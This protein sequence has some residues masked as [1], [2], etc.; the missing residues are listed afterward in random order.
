MIHTL[1]SRLST[2]ILG[3]VSCTIATLSLSGCLSSDGS[4]S[5]PQTSTPTMVQ[6]SE[7]G[8]TGIELNAMLAYRGIPYAAAPVDELRFA[9][10]APPPQ[11][12]EPLT[13]TENF[14]GECPQVSATT[15][16]AAGQEDCL[17][18]NIYTPPNADNLPVMI[19]LHGGA[20]VFGSG[21]GEFDPSRLVSQ[22]VIVVTLN[23]RLGNLG[24]LAHPAL[25]SNSGNF[26]LMDQQQ[27]MAWV[28]N[29]ITA[30]GGNPDEIT[31]FGESAGG[32]SVLSHIVSPH[33]ENAGLFQRA[34]VHS[35]S[36]APFQ[37][38]KPAAQ[39]SGKLIAEQLGCTTPAQAVTCL[40]ALPVSAILSAQG[41]QAI[42]T[43]DASNDLL[44]KSIMQALAEG[45]F[46]TSLDI[47]IGSNQDEGTLFVALDEVAGKPLENE[48]TY[49]QRVA[50]FFRPYQTATP[51]DDV[52][53]ASDYL[54]FTA[55]SE[56]LYSRALSAIWTDFMFACNSQTHA[57]SF[58]KASMNTYQYWF[59]DEQAPWALI[60]P[61]FV[62]FP[63]GA[64]HASDVPYVLY[65][66]ETME[67]RYTGNINELNGLAASMVDYWTQFAKDG[68]P[69]TVDGVAAVWPQVSS[70]SLLILD[71]PSPRLDSANTFA[72]YHHCS[73]WQRP[74]LK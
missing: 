5:N 54:R 35:G 46:N 30:F 12:S 2:P 64:S 23:Y 59:R 71:T 70:G 37:M 60:N 45:S 43:V 29:N 24:F 38:P 11:H 72:D 28:K 49:R 8:V 3:F 58:A 51:F 25:E 6:T 31:L 1:R 63:L 18:L 53:I 32:Q 36:Y 68:N 34:I 17:F 62:S 56:H 57:D 44:P 40:R 7:G 21:G 16:A 50:D 4:G 27:A 33:A 65:S 67:K 9:P 52:Q 73:Y 14:A 61:A 26:G 69:N 19:W 22:D 13:L 41:S 48:A 20:F 47:M 66:Q 74:P 39:A 15:G 42:P 55:D 10:P